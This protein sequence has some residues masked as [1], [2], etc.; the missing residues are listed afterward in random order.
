[1]NTDEL[2]RRRAAK[3]DARVVDDCLRTIADVSQ[4]VDTA[5]LVIASKRRHPSGRR[6][7]DHEQETDG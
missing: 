1:M 2:A 5:A 7:Y 4:P 6:P 3:A